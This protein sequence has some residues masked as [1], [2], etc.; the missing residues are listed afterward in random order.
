[1]RR[2]FYCL[3]LIALCLL[4]GSAAT[5]LATANG[6]QFAV[7]NNLATIPLPATAGNPRRLN[8]RLYQIRPVAPQDKFVIFVAREALLADE[9][10]KT[11]AALVVQYRKILAAEGYQILALRTVGD[12]I[13]ADFRTYAKVPWQKVG[14][15]FVRGRARFTRT[16]T[17]ELVGSILLCDPTQ[18]TSGSLAPFKQSVATMAISG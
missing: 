18:W 4:I 8:I 17:N 3:G 11:N 9:R 2:R 13:E 12:V 14:K 7:F 5:P 15:S 10:R 1:M 16:P 6:T